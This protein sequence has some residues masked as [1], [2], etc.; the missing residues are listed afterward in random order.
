MAKKFLDDDGFLHKKRPKFIAKTTN[1]KRSVK[2]HV[3][4]TD[5][6]L[7]EAK[8]NVLVF[9]IECYPNYFLVAFQD[10]VS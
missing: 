8:G 9:D 6:E 5:Q 2:Q 3:Y 7:H 10:Y 4:F 1:L